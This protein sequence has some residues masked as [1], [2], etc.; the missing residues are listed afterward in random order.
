MS[1][2]DQYRSGRSRTSG[3]GDR[4][5]SIGQCV[6]GA[7]YGAASMLPLLHRLAAAGL[8]TDL[9]GLLVVDAISWRRTRAIR[10]GRPPPVAGPSRGPPALAVLGSSGAGASRTTFL[11][12]AAG[13]WVLAYGA[14]MP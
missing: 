12:G 5:R 10:A 7:R 3:R 9:V 2:G 4:R 1:T 6:G 13:L 14:T 11:A 8:V